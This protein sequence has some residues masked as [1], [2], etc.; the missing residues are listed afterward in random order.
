M[1]SVKSLVCDEDGAEVVEFAL[2]AMI[3]FTLIFGIIEFCLVI[4]AGN[5]VAIAAQQ[6]TRY[7]M[8]RGSDW[9]SSC[10]SVSSYDDRRAKLHIGPGGRP[11]LGG[12]Q[13]YG[14]LADYNGGRQ[15]M[16]AVQS[17]MPG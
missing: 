2:A 4:Y 10:A 7:A 17:G 13:H 5:S 8:V 9:T 11:Q 12:K 3:F 15:H 16:H 1:R 14:Y 6:G